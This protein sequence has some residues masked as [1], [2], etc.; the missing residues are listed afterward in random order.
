MAVR[1]GGGHH[2]VCDFGNRTRKEVMES[3]NLVME[4]SWKSHGNLFSNFCGNPV[5]IMFIIKISIM[6]AKF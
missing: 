4:K 5:D 2:T 1:G 3:S 6:C